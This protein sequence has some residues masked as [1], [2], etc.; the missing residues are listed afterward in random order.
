MLQTALDAAIFISNQD[1]AKLFTTTDVY[2]NLRM[3]GCEY[4]DGIK[5]TK[6]IRAVNRGVHNHHD[7]EEYAFTTR[8]AG[9]AVPNRSYSKLKES[10]RKIQVNLNIENKKQ[11]Q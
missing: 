2:E 9:T 10:L 6:L 11:T 7:R 4:I 1:I 3:L 8:S 5:L